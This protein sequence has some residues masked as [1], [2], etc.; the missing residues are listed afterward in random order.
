MKVPLLDL[1]AQYQAIKGEIDAA[2]ME[3]VASQ[4]FIMGPKVEALEKGVAGYLDAPYAVAVSSGTDALILALMALGI[5]KG[6][7]VITSSYTFFATA[8]SIARVGAKPVFADICEDT[9]NINPEEVA[10]KITK[11]TKA[12]IPVH[13]FGQ[14]ADM[15]PL[16]EIARKKK[17]KIIEDGAQ[18]IGAQYKG[19][20]LCTLGLVGTLSFFPSKNLGGMGDGGMVITRDPTLYEFM[21]LLRNHGAQP[22]YYHK[23]IGGNFRLDAL[24]AAVL[25]VKLKYLEGWSEKRRQNGAYYDSRFKGTAV[26]LPA[27]RP[28]NKTI[29]NQYVIRVKD[30]DGLIKHLGEKGVGCEVYYP[31]PLHLQE[32][33]AYLGGK[34]GDLPVSE[35]AAKHSLALPVYPEM[36]ADMLKYSADSV[37]EFAGK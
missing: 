33:F 27:V 26:A 10:K 14:A 34:A 12:I 9:F 13:L 6:D 36:T 1:K 11:K 2:V 20:K 18:A 24:Q 25:S 22:K 15:D 3:T 16:L 23:Y 7:E 17:L 19:K 5:G 21:K 30:R 29:Y 35:E 28:G 8:G 31:L 4:H 32:C 37:L